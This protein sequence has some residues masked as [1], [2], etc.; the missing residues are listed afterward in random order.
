MIA[1]PLEPL[2][3]DLPAKPPSAHEKGE[4]IDSTPPFPR[5]AYFFFFVAFLAAFFFAGIRQIPPFGPGMDRSLPSVNMSRDK[6]LDIL[7]VG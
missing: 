4:V 5:G 2:R 3:S 1:H 7:G 6:G